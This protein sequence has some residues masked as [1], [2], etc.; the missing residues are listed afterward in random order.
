VRESIVYRNNCSRINRYTPLE[1]FEMD[2]SRRGRDYRISR[3]PTDFY[4]T[5]QF[6]AGKLWLE[7]LFKNRNLRVYDASDPGC[8]EKY[9][10]KTDLSDF[11]YFMEGGKK[12]KRRQA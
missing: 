4:T 1:T 8:S 10:A 2:S 9:V 7:D 6:L 5:S 12:R 11:F 3:G